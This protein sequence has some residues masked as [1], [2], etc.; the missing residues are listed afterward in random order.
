[1]LLADGDDQGGCDSTLRGAWDAVD[2]SRRAAHPFR[3]GSLRALGGFTVHAPSL[4]LELRLSAPI[5]LQHD[6]FQAIR[7]ALMGLDDPLS[8]GAVAEL[9][10]ERRDLHI[11]LEEAGHGLV[12]PF[13]RQDGLHVLKQRVV[14]DSSLRGLRAKPPCKMLSIAAHDVPM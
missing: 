8:G 11:G 5:T 13:P 7:S 3:L 6:A 12:I 14:D 1:M 9:L 10:D 4:S 2:N